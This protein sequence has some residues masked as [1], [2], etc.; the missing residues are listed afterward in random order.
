MT[1][2]DKFREPPLLQSFARRCGRANHSMDIDDCIRDQAMLEG[3]C[4]AVAPDKIHFR[5]GHATGLDC[6]L[7]RRFLT[8]KSY[9][10]CCSIFPTQKK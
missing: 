1:V 2:C 7:H 6:V 10:R 9:D 3:H 4:L 5:M 8:E